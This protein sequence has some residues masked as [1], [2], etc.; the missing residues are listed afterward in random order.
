MIIDMRFRA[1]HRL[2]IFLFQKFPDAQGFT[3]RPSLGIAAA[4]C[5]RSVSVHDFRDVPQAVSRG[6]VSAFSGKQ[7]RL[8]GQ[9]HPGARPWQGL[10]KRPATCTPSSAVVISGFAARIFIAFISRPIGVARIV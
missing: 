2:F 9:F 5:V 6:P 8:C 7:E 10:H 3:N 1:H 4:G